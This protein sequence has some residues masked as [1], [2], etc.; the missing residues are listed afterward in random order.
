MIFF[1]YFKCLNIDGGYFEINE[2]K[3]LE[4]IKFYFC[5]FDVYNFLLPIFNKTNP[6]GGSNHRYITFKLLN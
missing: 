1:I 2:A 4:Y 6:N 5:P 3:N